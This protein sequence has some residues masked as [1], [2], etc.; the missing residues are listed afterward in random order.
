MKIIIFITILISISTT[1][2]ANCSKYDW[3]D[4]QKYT[5]E[6]INYYKDIVLKIN[7]LCIEYSGPRK[8]DNVLR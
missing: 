1:T 5:Q 3:E 2:F 7:K 4:A 8:L 6:A